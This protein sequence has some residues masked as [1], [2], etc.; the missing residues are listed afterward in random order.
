[1][2][3]DCSIEL[4]QQILAAAES[5][6]ALRI[7]GGASKSFMLKGD[8]GIALRVADH[9]GITD[10]QPTE[11]VITARAGTPLSELEN[12]LHAQ[13]QLLPSES[14]SFAGKATLG[15]TVASALNGPRS[16]FAAS[17]RDIVLGCKLINGRGEILSFGG[18]VIKNVAG[19]DVSRLMVGS[20]GILGVLLEVSLKVLPKPHAEITLAV[21]M[22][23]PAQALAFAN[24]L[25][26]SS[27]PISAV[28]FFEGL[29]RMRV[30][31]NEVTVKNVREK[32]GGEL[33]D[34]A[35]WWQL[36]HLELPFF[37]GEAPALWRL[38]LAANTPTLPLSGDWLIDQNGAQRWYRGSEPAARIRE[39]CQQAGG[40]ATY[41]KGDNED[42]PTFHP[43]DSQL[44]AWHQRLK[45]A[46][47]PHRLFNANLMY[48]GL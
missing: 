17:L 8:E 45:E 25:I 24:K 9:S 30:S 20:W 36:A 26:D 2:A 13:G 7:V 4:Q 28:S 22:E 18:R 40:H 44:M 43:L 29:L 32:I 15:G 19:Y 48:P 27:L 1:M 37:S 14:P 5:R 33:V 34:G 11:M 38:S 47:D 42:I 10:Y 46:F 21:E 41:V 16:A 12:A 3:G 35:F 39:L 6:H 31:G 23:S